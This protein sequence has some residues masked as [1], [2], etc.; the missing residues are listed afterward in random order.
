MTA[1]TALLKSTGKADLAGTQIARVQKI[2][3]PARE[4][5]ADLLKK[6]HEQPLSPYFDAP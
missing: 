2:R 1:E 6:F 4:S 5:V 3:G